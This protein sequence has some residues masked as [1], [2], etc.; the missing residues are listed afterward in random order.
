MT[1]TKSKLDQYT[2]IYG[3]ASILLTKKVKE[4]AEGIA[5]IFPVAVKFTSRKTPD[6]PLYYYC[7]TKKHAERVAENSVNGRKDY[8]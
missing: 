5:N 8:V 3:T 1:T 4:A 7:R 6:K 2:G